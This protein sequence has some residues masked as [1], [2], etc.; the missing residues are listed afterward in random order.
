MRCV[1]GFVVA[2]LLAFTIAAQGQS[3]LPL[4]QPGELLWAGAF[5][6]PL[7][8]FGTS[9]F[10][11]GGWAL[12][13]H[14]ANNS[15][16]VVGHEYQ[17]H[18]AEINI[19]TPVQGTALGALPV[20][21]VRQVFADATEGRMSQIGGYPVYR[22]GGLLVHAG[23][24]I[25]AAYST[26][27]TGGTAISSH[28]T[29]SLTLNA[30]GTVTGMHRVGSLNP[31]FYAGNMATVPS[32]WQASLGGPAITGQCCLS[33]IS[34]TSFGPAAFAFDPTQLAVTNPTPAV[35]LVYY[36][37]TNPLQP[38]DAS[39]T[40]EFNNSTEMAGAFIPEGRRSLLFIGRHGIGP[41]CYRCGAPDPYCPG[42]VQA[43]P[44]Q[45]Q[46]WAY[47]LS[48]LAAVKAGQRMPWEPRPYAIW[49]LTGN[50]HSSPLPFFHSCMRVRGLAYDPTTQRVFIAAQQVEGDLPVV[51]VFR[52]GPASPTNVRIV[53]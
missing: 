34:R 38:W 28:F 37:S 16:F 33:I 41:F 20:A 27:D 21:S 15:L 26:F 32:A 49:A 31:A 13:Y 4:V 19:P 29:H 30:A 23:R 43:P 39:N 18:V 42:D 50:T 52:M 1:A 17:Q 47:D 22:M 12:A 3:P 40:L 10:D 11:Y 6:L 44:Y 51:H 46:V 24:L 5:R 14:A 2:V 53:R 35:P 7:G 45:V 48:V 25:G 9:R 36:P 8:A